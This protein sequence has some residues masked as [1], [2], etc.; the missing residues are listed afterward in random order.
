MVL[1]FLESI[2]YAGLLWP[3]AIVR[4]ILGYFYLDQAFLRS[5]AGHFDFAYLNEAIRVG[6]RQSSAP[7]WYRHFLE[8]VVQE[9]WQVFTYIFFGIELAIGLSYILGYL[10][11]PFALLAMALSVHSIWSLGTPTA[12][13]HYLLLL[14]H[15]MMLLLGA[16]RCL[17]FDYFYYRRR[18]GLWW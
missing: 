16:G 3:V 11:R 8:G 10:V 1:A 18:R 4:L 7:D 12:P 13:F 15:S 17:G 14:F 9:Q 6:L 2:K 5:R